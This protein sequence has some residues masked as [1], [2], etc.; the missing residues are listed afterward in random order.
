M[1]ENSQHIIGKEEELK[2]LI[3]DLKKAKEGTSSEE[4][5]S[6]MQK[7]IT[8]QHQISQEIYSK[9]GEQQ[10]AEPNPEQPEQEHP[11]NAV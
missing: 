2:T 10:Q 6:S 5:N 3:E 8:V 11:E 4:I 9:V 7:L 1:K